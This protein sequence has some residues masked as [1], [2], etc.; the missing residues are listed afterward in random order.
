MKVFPEIVAEI[1]FN[2]NGDVSLACE[3]IKA[4]ASAGA[5]AV[6]FQ[7]FLASDLALKSSEHYNI[8]KNGELSLTEHERLIKT[9][10]ENGIIFL[11][12]PFS[13]AGVDM[14][15]S[16]NIS[17][18]KV[19]SMDIT[20]SPLLRHISSTGKPMI[21]STGMAT[22]S[23]IAEALDVIK[24]TGRNKVI[25]L[26][27]VSK[28][29]T[30][31]DEA[32]LK[33]IP[34]LKSVF[35]VPVGYSDH[36]LGNTVAMSAIAVGAS[37][38]EKHFTTDKSLPGP[39]HKISS[40]PKELRTLIREIENVKKSLGSVSFCQDRVDR[41]EAILFRR[42]LYAKVNIPTGT[43]ITAEMIKCVRPEKGLKPEFVEYIIGRTARV[44]ISEED[45]ITFELI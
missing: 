3:M 34:F 4:A 16:L 2:H 1:G 41:K 27:C 39:D 33:S 6:K 25:L 32:N 44:D 23:E 13:R 30:A 26:H 40:D 21:V 22:I 38:I 45:P 8:I 15:E 35:S 14:L 20:N 24:Q 5:D 28:Y 43:V 11:S 9:A 42:S 18:Y 31:P 7:T 37:L 10:H 12:T 29:P 17:A 36:V 19:A